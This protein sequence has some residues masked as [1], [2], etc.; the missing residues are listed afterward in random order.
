MQV[1]VW[2][3]FGGRCAMGVPMSGWVVIMHV[4]ARGA[5]GERRMRMGWRSWPDARPLTLP[6]LPRRDLTNV[7]MLV[8][9]LYAMAPTQGWEHA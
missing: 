1:M 2:V 7:P 9:W 3:P 5:G 8:T 4:F 6:D